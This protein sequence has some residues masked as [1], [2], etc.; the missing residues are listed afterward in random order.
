MFLSRNKKNN[1]YPSKPQF[2]Y[3]K[4]GLKGQNYIGMC[5]WWHSHRTK[6]KYYSR[7]T[8]VISGWRLPDLASSQPLWPAKQD[9]RSYRVRC[10]HCNEQ[11]RY[12]MKTNQ[13]MESQNPPKVT[14]TV[15]KSNY[16][17]IKFSV[18]FQYFTSLAALNRMF[19]RNMVKIRCRCAVGIS[20][21]A[22]SG[23]PISRNTEVADDRGGDFLCEPLSHF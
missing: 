11:S 8:P 14:A 9:C 13:E 4:V 15:R 19:T 7:N 17:H 5:S 2:H 16:K 23:Y 6:I 12:I 22:H 20:H 10:V 3:I 18:F 21:R 1:V